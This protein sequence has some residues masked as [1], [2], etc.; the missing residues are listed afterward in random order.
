MESTKRNTGSTMIRVVQNEKGNSRKMKSG[1]PSYIEFSSRS[2]WIMRRHM[3]MPWMKLPR[4]NSFERVPMS[5][6][7]TAP[8]NRANGSMWL[9]PSANAENS[10]RSIISMA[11]KNIVIGEKYRDPYRGLSAISTGVVKMLAKL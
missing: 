11:E 8:L 2:M 9:M 3:R 6:R 4:K 7:P 5:N 1:G 10:G